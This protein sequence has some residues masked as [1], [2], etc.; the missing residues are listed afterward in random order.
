MAK[1]V[2]RQALAMLRAMFPDLPD[3]ARAT[4]DGPASVFVGSD[5]PPYF[6]RL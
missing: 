6:I 4:T 2:R 3:L 1:P 5:V